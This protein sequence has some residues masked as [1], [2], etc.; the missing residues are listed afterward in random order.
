M[1]QHPTPGHVSGKDENS[2][3]KRYTY[4]KVHSSMMYNNQDMKTTQV[5][6]NR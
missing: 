4:P 3:L 5:P 2:N 6:I 1:T